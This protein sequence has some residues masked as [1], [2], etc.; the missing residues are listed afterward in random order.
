[1]MTAGCRARCCTIDLAQTRQITGTFTITE[2]GLQIVQDT[3]PD[4]EYW[5]YT[6]KAIESARYQG[7]YLDDRRRLTVAP[8]TYFTPHT[9]TTQR[10]AIRRVPPA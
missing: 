8:S 6:L 4:D 5:Q 7:S 1:M 2:V 10:A 3:G 9:G